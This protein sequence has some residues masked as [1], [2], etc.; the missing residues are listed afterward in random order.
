[1][2]RTAEDSA[3]ETGVDNNDNT[4]APTDGTVSPAA[5][6][7]D[8]TKQQVMLTLDE[9]GAKDY[10]NGADGQPTPIGTQVRRK[11]YILRRWSQVANTQRGLI[12]KE[13]TRIEGRKVP[14]QIVFQATKGVPNTNVAVAAAASAAPEAPQG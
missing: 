2:A 11:D 4:A 1:M 9:Q 8:G 7:S 5:A 6:A 14:Y 12:S 10:G 3:A 13:L